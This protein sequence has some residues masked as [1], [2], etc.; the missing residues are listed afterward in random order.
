MSN[1]TR[2]R[3]LDSA[4]HVF[5]ERGFEAATNREIAERCGLTSASIYY[6]F[7]SKLDLYLAVHAGARATI[8]ERFEAVASSPAP[9]LTRLEAVLEASYALNQADP[10]LAKFLA[11]ARV[12]M[13]RRH[14]TAGELAQRSLSRAQ[15]FGR[16]VD[17]AVT[18]GEVLA[19]HR[20][21]VNALVVAVLAGMTDE[22]SGDSGNHRRVIEA[23]LLALRGML[24][25]PLATWSPPPA[26][27]SAVSAWES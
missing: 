23:F 17:D 27:S 12:D 9:F 13:M 25:Q 6:Y 11:T 8:Y 1:E 10:S 21:L 7:E 16:M 15:F 3:I 22:M 5:A 26:R 2:Q 4:R 19:E 20:D 18:A 24:V 14:D